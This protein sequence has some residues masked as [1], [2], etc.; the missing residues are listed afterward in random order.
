MKTYIVVQESSIVDLE[1]EVRL[2]LSRGYKL[3][4]GLT[5]I[6]G[7]V[8]NRFGHTE[9]TSFS[10]MGQG[11]VRVTFAQALYLEGN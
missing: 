3:A 2:Q 4:G 8:D 1:K 6:Q 9:W 11:T 5:T 10:S 7:S